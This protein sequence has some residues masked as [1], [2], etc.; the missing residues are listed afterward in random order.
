MANRN[1]D[2]FEYDIAISFAGEDRAIAD[3]L[4]SF[5]GARGVRVFYDKYEQAD[6]WGRDLYQH[7]DDVY[8]KQARFCVVLLSKHYAA[9]LWTNHEL[10]SAQARAFTDSAPYILPVK[11]DDTEIPGVRPTLGYID[12]RDT[13]VEE[14]TS[15]VIQKLGGDVEAKP[16][17]LAEAAAPVQEP[18]IPMPRVKRTFTDYDRDRFLQDAFDHIR[19]YFSRAV[20][21]LD[22]RQPTTQVA[23]HQIDARTFSASVYLDGKRGN[24]CEVWI[25]APAGDGIAYAEGSTISSGSRNSYN[26]W[27]TVDTDEGQIGL[28]PAMAM[29]HT[30]DID[31][32]ALLSMEQA[33]QYLW[34]RFIQPLE[35]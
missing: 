35:R 26:D 17:L 34:K 18:A 6:L 5:L 16:Q 25:G 4:A 9:K 33:A 32:N 31:R 23:F 1:N 13:T 28:R 11:L 30:P 29:F 15:L 2:R 27:L 14:L 22:E 24:H 20:S 21:L 3:T 19:D 8:R 10:K 7:L 12:L